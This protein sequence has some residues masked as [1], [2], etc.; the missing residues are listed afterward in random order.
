MDRGRNAIVLLCLGTGLVRSSAFGQQLPARFSN[1]GKWTMSR[2]LDNRA[3]IEVPVPLEI[4]WALWDD[5][6]RIP[7]W[8]PWIKSVTVQKDIP[9]MSRWTLSTHQFGRD[10][11]FSWLARNLAPIRNQKLHWVS[12]PGSASMGLNV[13]NRG[14]IR[15]IRRPTGCN[16]S[17]SISYEVPDVLA[18]FA[19][20]L[21]PVV[22]GII[23]KDMERFRDYATAYAKAQSSSQQQQQVPQL[24]CLADVFL[25]E[26]QVVMVDA[27]QPEWTGE[28]EQLSWKPRAYLM[29][30]FL[31]EAECDHIVG[32]AKPK[33]E[34]SRVV[35]SQ[36][37][38]RKQS[39][40]RTSTGAMFGRAHDDVIQRIE[41]RIASVTMIPV[42]HQEGLQVLHYENGQK[43]DVHFDAFHDAINLQ[44]DLGGQRVV[45][46]LM[47]LS[48]PE[49]GGETVFPYAEEKVSGPGWSQC[50]LLGLAHHPHKGD[51]IMFY[52]LT[53]DGSVDPA[54]RHGSCPTLKG[55]KWSAT[56]WIHVLK[57]SM[58]T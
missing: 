40:V 58:T 44:P 24:L 47:Y 9:A 7:Q 31:S 25:W 39:T 13:N 38:V 34:V 27:A 26:A 33:L 57:V 21:T 37:G 16:V 15:F 28:I 35:D 49:E 5:R 50:A 46:V 54:S 10:W 14:Q 43:Y 29:R 18:P 45:T 30:H 8:M 52:S 2:W 32:L 22:E 55:E 4:C 56:K 12:E 11:E 51:A 23:S 42:E 6:E 41:R 20:A 17:L 48:T 1:G 3:E 19:N 53:P 36:S